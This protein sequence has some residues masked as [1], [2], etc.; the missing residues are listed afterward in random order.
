MNGLREGKERKEGEDEE[1]TV[2]DEGRGRGRGR[3]SPDLGK[4]RPQTL[5]DG[6]KNGSSKHKKRS[7]RKNDSPRAAYNNR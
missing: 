1:E 5:I 7:F 4:H 2:R 6:K 3:V